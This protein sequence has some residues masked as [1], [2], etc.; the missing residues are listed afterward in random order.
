[1][2]SCRL[3][4]NCIIT[5]MAFVATGVRANNITGMAEQDECESDSLTASEAFVVL[6]AKAL[7]ILSTSNR[8]D[9]LD[10]YKVDSICD[11]ANSMEGFSHLNPPLNQD[12]LQV[13]VTP[14]S[15]L[16]VRILPFKKERIVATIYTVGDSLQAADSELRFYDE[17]MNELKRSKFIKIP[18]T[19]DFMDF[20]GVDGKL[21][22][23]LL[24]LVPFP[25]V[26]LTMDSEST[27]LKAILTV[28]EFMSKEDYATILPYLRR[29]R[30]YR[31]DG[32]KYKLVPLK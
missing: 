32:S 5:I 7:D 1:M 6:P 28:G 13:Q 26:E 10:Y 3:Y 15:K 22:H 11:I 8:L 29:E 12:Y 23:E 2:K 4:L 9:M 27:D 25:T 21:K 19:S 30:V 17:R 24:E 16:S 31:W 14:V 18:D 20:K